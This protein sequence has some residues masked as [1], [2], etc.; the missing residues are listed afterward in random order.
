MLKSS[1]TKI[2]ELHDWDQL[3]KETYNRPYSLQQQDGCMERQTIFLT[4]P[5]FE[6][7]KFVKEHLSK[8]I[9]DDIPEEING[10]TMEVTL[11]SWLKRDPSLR[12]E[13]IKSNFDN[14]LFWHRNFYPHLQ[15]L[16]N[17]LYKRGLIE[18]G[19]YGIVIDW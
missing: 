4:I 6:E 17:D 5:D 9:H 13:N 11:E 8:Y 19:E 2:V 3:V 12:T 18:S 16:A 14:Q 7:E 1:T 15:I 10:N